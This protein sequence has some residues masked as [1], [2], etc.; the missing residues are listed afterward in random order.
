VWSSSF[1]TGLAN[2]L[3]MS[4]LEGVIPD[5]KDARIA[6]LWQLPVRWT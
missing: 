5:S 2:V 3:L 4:L 1:R 6:P